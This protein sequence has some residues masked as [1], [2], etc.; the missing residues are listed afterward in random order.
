MSAELRHPP[1]RAPV[2]WARLRGALCAPLRNGRE[3]LR[4]LWQ[5]DPILRCQLLLF[6]SFQVVNMFWDQPGVYGWENDGAAPRAFLAGIADNLRPGSADR[7][8][9]FHYLWIALVS[10]P[11]LVVDVAVAASTGQ[12]LPAVVTSVASMTAIALLTKLLHAAMLSVA[13]LALG[14]TF[15]GLFGV[16]AARWGVP[17]CMLNLSVAYYGRVT[18]VDVAYLMWIALWLD[19]L[20]LCARQDERRHYRWLAF[21]AAAALATKDQAYAA[22]LLPGLVFLVLLPLLGA[23]SRAELQRHFGGL[24]RTLA[25]ALG[26]YLLFSGAAF[27]PSGFVRR[28]QQLAGSNSQD[29]RQ[30]APSGAGLQQNLLDLFWLQDDFW[31]PWPVVGVAWLGALLAPRL[32]WSA[33]AGSEVR[34]GQ[35][36]LPGHWAWSWLPLSA[37]VSSVLAFTLVVG[38]A[39]HR[40]LLPLG[41][42][43]AGY[44]GVLIANLAFGPNERKGLRTCLGVG[45]CSLGLAQNLELCVTQWCDPRRDV[46]R[47]LAALPAGARVETYGLGVYL[48]RFDLSPGASYRVT[49]V[50]PQASKPP[51]RITGLYELQA[52]LGALEQRQPDLIVLPEGFAGR[53]RPHATDPAHAPPRAMDVY[54]A[55][56]GALELFGRALLDDLP[57]YRLLTVGQLRLPDGYRWLGGRA[58]QIHGSTGQPVWVLQRTAAREHL[59]LT[60][61]GELAAPAPR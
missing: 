56:P 7:Y 39:E 38:R 43:L 50:S 17:L 1:T 27:N 4:R 37:G 25:L 3:E 2:R 61:S 16:R 9:L 52:D 19:R 12:A 40:F 24:G 49:R 41:F 6:L 18:N 57:H 54:R 36:L 28:L 21:C 30:Y 42:C 31:W 35:R 11:V 10:L 20:L 33:E 60:P 15:G 32:R 23:G 46:E 45:L 48:P 58:H 51:P 22:M 53:F 29:W 47:F 5:Q 26:L 55:A 14:R 13:L 8:P 34:S 44:A 59:A